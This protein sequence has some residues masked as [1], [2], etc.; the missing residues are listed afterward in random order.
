MPP[1]QWF[2]LCRGRGQG[3]RLRG[4]LTSAN[5]DISIRLPEHSINRASLFFPFF[6]PIVDGTGLVAADNHDILQSWATSHDQNHTDELFSVHALAKEF[7][8]KIWLLK[9][10]VHINACCFVRVH[11]STVM[12]AVTSWCNK[13]MGGECLLTHRSHFQ[14]AGLRMCI[15]QPPDIYMHHTSVSQNNSI[16][17][18]TLLQD[19]WGK[20]N[21]NVGRA[22]IKCL[23]AHC[24]TNNDFFFGATWNSYP[25]IY[26]ISPIN[27]TNK[28]N[29]MSC[30]K[31]WLK[32]TK[33][34]NSSLLIPKL[35]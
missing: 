3:S 17:N 1:A 30:T 2:I 18:N 23:T 29:A 15:L 16:N 20:L 6:P 11:I 13:I 28:Q 19:A 32:S 10:S 9:Q 4:V 7:H 24:Y 33:T 14:N 12:R 21:Q 31:T 22:D 27:K 26:I 35:D 8:K 25:S 34:R 5:V